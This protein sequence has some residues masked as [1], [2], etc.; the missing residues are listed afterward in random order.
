MIRFSPTALALAA[1]LAGCTLM[2]TYQQPAAPVPA[3]FAGA[4]DDRGDTDGTRA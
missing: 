3:A 2:P 1:T 4:S